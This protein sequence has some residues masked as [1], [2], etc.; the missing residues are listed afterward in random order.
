MLHQLQEWVPAGYP[1]LPGTGFGPFTGR[2]RGASGDFLWAEELPFGPL[3]MRRAAYEA[4]IDA[5]LRIGAA[6]ETDIWGRTGRLVDIMQLEPA[7]GCIFVR[8]ET[9]RPATVPCTACQLNTYAPPLPALP[10]ERSIGADGRRLT[11]HE[12]YLARRAAIPHPQLDQ[13]TWP[14]GWDIAQVEGANFCSEAFMATAAR[15]G[16]THIVFEERDVI[17][18][19]HADRVEGST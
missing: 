4:L 13:T 15:L 11:R 8:P 1:V 16:L 14:A 18:P 7:G 19:A 10:P 9:G 2:L 6:H 12:E 5:G 17:L 3:L